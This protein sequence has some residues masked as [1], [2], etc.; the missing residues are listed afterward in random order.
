MFVDYSGLGKRKTSNIIYRIYRTYRNNY[1]RV[2][3]VIFLNPE[4]AKASLMPVCTSVH[5]TGS[6]YK[7]SA[8]NSYTLSIE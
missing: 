4:D 7:S 5:I 8:V 6:D 1:A 3:K 2:Q